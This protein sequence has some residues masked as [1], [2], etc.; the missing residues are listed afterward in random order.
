MRDENEKNR[1]N[2]LLNRINST[3][4]DENNNLIDDSTNKVINLKVD[5]RKTSQNSNRDFNFEIAALATTEKNEKK[6]S[7]KRIENVV[8]KDIKIS[9]N[10]LKLKKID[11][12]YSEGTTTTNTNSTPPFYKAN[13]KPKIGLNVVHPTEETQNNTTST[14]TKTNKMPNGKANKLTDIESIA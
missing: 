10:L 5:K 13:E 9:N 6:S 2:E 12:G 14:N 11:S 8:L 4:L 7:L 1:Q 3:E